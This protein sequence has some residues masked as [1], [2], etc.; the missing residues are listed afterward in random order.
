V[1]ALQNLLNEAQDI[2]L[3]SH[4]HASSDDQRSPSR[5]VQSR[6][7]SQD[8][9]LSLDDAENPLQMLARASDIQLSQLT[10]TSDRASMSPLSRSSMT[11]RTMSDRD[12]SDLHWFFAPIR[13]NP[14]FGKDIGPDIDPIELGLATFEE[15]STLFQ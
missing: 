1:L 12:K 11:V 4:E 13:A 15:A 10:M 5:L 2:L 8:D 6:Q 7:L 3:R 9:N 14:D